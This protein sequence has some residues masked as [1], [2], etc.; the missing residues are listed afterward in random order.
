MRILYV[1]QGYFSHYPLTPDKRVVDL[2][3]KNGGAM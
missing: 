3:N 1:S 2:A